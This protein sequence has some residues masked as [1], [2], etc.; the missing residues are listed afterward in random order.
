MTDRPTPSGS[1]WRTPPWQPRASARSRGSALGPSKAS[2]HN[3]ARI[4]VTHRFG[5]RK[6]PH[7]RRQ[8]LR[9]FRPPKKRAMYIWMHV[10]H[11]HRFS[12]KLSGSGIDL[13][14]GAPKVIQIEWRL[15]AQVQKEQVTRTCFSLPRE[16]SEFIAI[17]G[18]V[19]FITP[20]S[21][22][23]KFDQDRTCAALSKINTF[24]PVGT[25]HSN[26]VL[27]PEPSK[28]SI[29]IAEK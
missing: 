17:L 22:D 21:S 3:R 7:R 14:V 25:S 1:S 11:A 5:N 2:V 4:H 29:Q 20:R 26:L 27:S 9:C 10:N 13:F 8:S 28:A 15:F 19:N 24:W 12:L 16:L 18:T 6:Y 23:H